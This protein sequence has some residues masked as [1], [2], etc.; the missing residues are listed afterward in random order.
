LNIVEI[1]RTSVK[2]VG[3][4]ITSQEGKPVRRTLC[5][6]DLHTVVVGRILVGQSINLSDVRELAE[7]RP[8]WLH[9]TCAASVTWVAGEAAWIP[10]GIAR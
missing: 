2:S 10:G 4:G 7:V 8:E 1:V 3:V 5:E 6:R 9:G